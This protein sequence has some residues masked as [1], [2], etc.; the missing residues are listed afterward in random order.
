MENASII[1]VVDGHSDV[2]GKYASDVWIDY[3]Q[4]VNLCWQTLSA[5]LILTLL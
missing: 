2:Q 5:T 4:Y 1:E 3:L